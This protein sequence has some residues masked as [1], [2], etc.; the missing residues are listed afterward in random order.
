L[1][2]GQKQ[3]RVKSLI[4]GMEFADIFHSENR[5]DNFYKNERSNKVL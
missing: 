3:F 4:D 2:N 1:G 5:I